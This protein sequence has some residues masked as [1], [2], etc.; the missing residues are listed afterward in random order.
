MQRYRRT[1]LLCSARPW[2][3]FFFFLTRFSKSESD[4]KSNQAL[5]FFASL[6]QISTEN[7]I[8]SNQNHSKSESEK[9]KH[10]TKSNEIEKNTSQRRR[11]ARGAKEAEVM[12]PNREYLLSS[13]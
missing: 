10:Q 1:V 2:L 12:R 8:K 9:R 7:Q 5:G 4:I 13:N 11:L 6:L 3:C